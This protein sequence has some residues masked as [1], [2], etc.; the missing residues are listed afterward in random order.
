MSK[1]F[2]HCS[3]RM[4]NVRR[5]IIP[6]IAELIKQTPGTLSLGQGVVY[7]NP[8]ESICNTI[9]QSMSHHENQLY[10]EVTGI[11]SLI[12]IINDKLKREN[13]I[14]LNNS[15]VVVTAGA[16]MGFLNA[17]FAITEPD[18]EIILLK[19]YYFNHEMAIEML[20]CRVKAVATDEQ[21][22]PVLANIASAITGKT[23]AIVTVSPNNPAGV[24]YSQE[25]LEAIN[26]LCR[27]KGLYHIS[28]E[29]YE[30]FIFNDKTHHS[31][32]SFSDSNHHTISLFSLSKA[33]GFAS[34]RIGYMHIPEHLFEAVQKAQ[35][36]NLICP[37]LVS[38]YAALEI[39]KIGSDYSYEKI[40]L[41]REF[42][43]LCLSRLAKISSICRTSAADGAFYALLKLDTDMQSMQLAQRLI[44]E[45]RIATVPGDTFGLDS[46]CYLRVSYGALNFEDLEQAM[47]RL[48][49]GLSQILE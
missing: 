38:Q 33:Y 40:S 11:P 43:Q 29:A 2:Q 14:P 23:R 46:G 32:A 48:V 8:P 31:P 12:E 6:V 36:T 30:Y 28:D 24:V 44:K 47:E 41:L 9:S 42:R 4:Q 35:D 49:K 39:L 20:N 21:H 15:R 7:F 18:D 5:P 19:P 1:P 10:G 45:F 34:W 37:S 25:T 27:D 16:N 3:Q 17:L 13:L 22:Q 26:Q